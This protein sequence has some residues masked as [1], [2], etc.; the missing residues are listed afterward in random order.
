[1][2]LQL[3]SLNNQSLSSTLSSCMGTSQSHISEQSMSHH[4]NASI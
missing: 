3:V 1:M 2:S 4:S